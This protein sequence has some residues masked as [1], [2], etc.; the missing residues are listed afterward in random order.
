MNT[1]RVYLYTGLVVSEAGKDEGESGAEVESCTNRD[2]KGM[3][4]DWES[5]MW[6]SRAERKR[7]GSIVV[8]DVLSSSSSSL[9]I[10]RQVSSCV[11]VA[12]NDERCVGPCSPGEIGWLLC[13]GLEVAWALC[14]RLLF[15]P[16]CSNSGVGFGKLRTLTGL[17]IAVIL[18]YRD[19]VGL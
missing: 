6:S 15:L 10:W 3:L 12:L 8:G 4:R 14:R 18:R 19:D 16:C 17:T 11:A 13:R 1:I 9:I 7:V 5:K 2:L